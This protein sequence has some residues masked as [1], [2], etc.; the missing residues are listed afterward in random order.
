MKKFGIAVVKTVILNFAAVVGAFGGM[1]AVG[2]VIE[3]R[4]KKRKEDEKDAV[5]QDFGGQEQG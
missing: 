2:A 4:N 5:R 1:A 3:Q